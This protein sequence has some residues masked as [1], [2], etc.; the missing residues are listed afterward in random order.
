MSEWKASDGTPLE[1]N[2][3]DPEEVRRWHLRNLDRFEDEIAQGG[4]VS[5]REG[6]HLMADLQREWAADLRS[7]VEKEWSRA[8]GGDRIAPEAAALINGFMA[9]QNT[10]AEA[11]HQQATA[12]TDMEEVGAPTA[13]D[14]LRSKRK[15]TASGSK[16]GKA[17]KRKEW[18]EMAANSLA[19]E[20]EGLTKDKAWD[21]LPTSYSAWEFETDAAAFC[22]YRD[23]DTLC[24]E[25]LENGQRLGEIKKSAF[26]KRYYRK[27]GQ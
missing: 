27:A 23:G 24:A 20:A 13:I 26:L 2:P 4:E 1:F 21:K 8:S 25:D 9:Q 19:K 12:A 14:G 5:G 15:S 7:R 17:P 16:G 10:L 18:A 3:H 6:L 22:V 11:I